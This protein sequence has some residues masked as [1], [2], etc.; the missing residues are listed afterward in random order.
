MWWKICMDEWFVKGAAPK[1]MTNKDKKKNWKEAFFHRATPNAEGEASQS[2]REQQWKNDLAMKIRRGEINPL[3]WNPFDESSDNDSDNSTNA[4]NVGGKSKWLKEGKSHDE[5][6]SY[7]KSVRAKPKGKKPT[8]VT[9][10]W[11]ML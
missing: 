5:W 6:R 4:E 11:A 10:E 9:R 1:K 7:Y 3:N 8:H 2:V